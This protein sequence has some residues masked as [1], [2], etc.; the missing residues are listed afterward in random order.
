MS[1]YVRDLVRKFDRNSDGYLSLQE[2]TDGLGKIGIYLTQPEIRA[3]MTRM[4]LNRDGEVSA[5][6][7]L[8]VLTS[9]SNY[10]GPVGQLN[11]SIDAV[12]DKLAAGAK[13]FPTIKDYAR[14]LI[15]KFDRDNDG[16]ITFQELCDG[17]QRLNISVTMQ[18][19]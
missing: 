19:K 9:S 17:L 13:G 16:I 6:E 15:K 11:S 12:I 2:L 14:S 18:D 8:N 4:D 10:G 5:E 3:L 1:D 7:I